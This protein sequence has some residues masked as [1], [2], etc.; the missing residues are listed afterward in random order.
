MK[1]KLRIPTIK[2]L[3]FKILLISLPFVAL[4]L[5]VVSALIYRPR[6]I[7]SNAM[8]ISQFKELLL[9]KNISLPGTLPETLTESEYLQLAQFAGITVEEARV[10]F[11]DLKAEELARKEQTP[12]PQ[13]IPDS[14]PSP[15]P[16]IDPGGPQTTPEPNAASVVKLAILGDSTSDEY[17]ADDS[18]GGSYSGTTFNWNE[19]MARYRGVDLG[20]WGTR[21]EPRRQGYE[22]NFARSAAVAST[23]ISQNQ[24][25]GVASLVTAGKVNVVYLQ[26]GSN[27]FSIYTVGGKRD[28]YDICN[29]IMS[30]SAINTKL[31]NFEANISTALTTI[32]AT[33]NVPIILA[34]V[35]DPTLSAT[36]GASCSNPQRLKNTIA[37]LNNRL[38]TLASSKGASTFDLS[39]F[40]TNLLSRVSDGVITIE[41]ERISVAQNGDEPHHAILGDGIHLGT[42]FGGFLA[43]D[44]MK[45]INLKIGSTL[46]MFSELEILN[47]AGISVNTAPPSA[48]VLLTPLNG[49]RNMNDL[50]PTL[51]WADVAGVTSYKVQVAT[52]STFTDSSLVLDTITNTSKHDINVQ[53][54][55]GK[56]YYWRVKSI[57]GSLESS[58]STIYNF[59]TISGPAAPVLLTPASNTLLVSDKATLT[60]RGVTP[61]PTKYELQVSKNP[62]AT[63][64][65]GIVI[66]ETNIPTSLLSYTTQSL[67]K[68]TVYYWRVRAINGEIPGTWSTPWVFKLAPGTPTLISPNQNTEVKTNRPVFDWS[69]VQGTTKYY[70][71]VSTVPTFA[72]LV[73]PTAA[74][75]ES[76]Y[77]P[78]VNLPEGKTLYWRVRSYST[79]GYGAYSEVSNFVSADAPTTPTLTKPTTNTV[80]SVTPT[81]EWTASLAPVPDHYEVEISKNSLATFENGIVHENRNIKALTYTVTNPL[82]T[83]NLYYWRVRA[84]TSNGITSAWSAIRTMKTLASAPQLASPGNGASVNALR[85]VLDWSDISNATGYQVQASIT[86][87]FST[88]LINAA[89]TS[90][91]YTHTTD[92]PKN[93]TIYWRV[94]AK[95]L[96]GNSA[97]SS[98][99]SFITP[100]PPAVPVLL[101]PATKSKPATLSPTFEWKP[102]VTV[103]AEA[104]S[105]YELQ[106]STD[107]TFA[108]LGSSVVTVNA[109]TVSYT[110][111]SPLATS[112]T[113]YWRVRAVNAQGHNSSWSLVWQLTTIGK[114]PTIS[115]VT[116]KVWPT[117][118]TS[119]TFTHSH[120]GTN[121][122]LLLAVSYR[123]TSTAGV[124]S[125][126]TYGGTT[127]TLTRIRRHYAH[128]YYSELWYLPVNATPGDS[129]FTLTMSGPVDS[130]K[131]TAMTLNDVNQSTPLRSTLGVIAGANPSPYVG[132]GNHN[133]NIPTFGGELPIAI[134]TT[135]YNSG[136]I[137]SPASGLHTVRNYGEDNTISTINDKQPPTDGTTSTLFNWV[138]TQNWPW[139]AIGISVVGQ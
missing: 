89:T 2:R 93:K 103:G 134:H 26:I 105:K 38:K 64:D 11:A 75:T 55:S 91:T 117:K 43:N 66:N 46:P 4:A 128:E 48:P 109:P 123:S 139:S 102:V 70:I 125:K 17:R 74:T 104:A 3:P 7:G 27:D 133:L 88:L 100:A 129:T 30:D 60:W 97:W 96:G 31:A 53:L 12:V 80:V 1:K 16:Q 119:M 116:N 44:I 130:I 68:N 77:T 24:H 106:I 18:R 72:S 28:G 67:T 114:V 127:T 61:T 35:G 94:Y 90:S 5:I 121:K 20:P 10:L 36:W 25:T 21:S 65:S 138:T 45:A 82:P 81:L 50:T 39:A 69:D 95:S 120:S 62:L 23:M 136:N 99:H 84:V 124:V 8:D 115:T 47:N 19:L 87:T 101:R 51:D 108:N 49:E 9:K 135:Y 78:T 76:T 111:G 79:L 137:V 92:L 32:R 14:T 107:P 73:F 41:G 112:S 42:V 58:W 29:N 15:S 85:P 34:L 59:G 56:V 13:E 113:Y 83:G 52:L 63:F 132:T 37:T 57:R 118:L 71:S 110:V 126:V 86:T 33:G 122:F 22:Y 98:I 54:L 131:A 6:N 40:A